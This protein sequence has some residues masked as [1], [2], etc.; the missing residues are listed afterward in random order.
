MLVISPIKAEYL[1]GYS[2]KASFDA[3]DNLSYMDDT[4]FSGFVEH[5][6]FSVGDYV[7]V[8]NNNYKI[9]AQ[10]RISEIMGYDGPLKKA[11]SGMYIPRIDIDAELSASDDSLHI[12]KLNKKAPKDIF[13]IITRT[14]DSVFVDYACDY[15]TA[16]CKFLNRDLLDDNS[17]ED[18]WKN[19]KPVQVQGILSNLNTKGRDETL[20]P[21]RRMELIYLPEKNA[22]T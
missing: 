10:G 5:G 13:V 16:I 9:F 8:M 15:K 1:F 11:T 12:V 6:C 2:F 21:D 18:V 14:Y 3:E 17:L 7:Y 19:L 20:Y 4:A 22:F